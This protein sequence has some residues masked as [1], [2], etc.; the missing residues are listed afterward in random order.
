MAKE[1]R[2]S[3]AGRNADGHRIRQLEFMMKANESELERESYQLKAAG[4]R[5]ADEYK[6]QMAK[7]RRE[8][9]AFRNAEGRRIRDLE[10]MMKGDEW[11]REHE[12]Y[13]LKWAGERDADAY[14]KQMAKERRESLAFRNAESAKHDA[15]MKE[16]RQLAQEKEHESYMLK[17]AGE[18]DAKQYVKE[19]QELRRQSLEFRNAEGRRHRE[20]EENMRASRQ[21][22]NELNEEIAAACKF[23]YRSSMLD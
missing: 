10:T 6:Q 15:V 20:I 13:E 18:N 5:D 22:E 9:L 11:E 3:L 8:S 7:E 2:E 1:R 19:Q 21:R 14:K 12:S 16:L 23:S 17:W 4:E